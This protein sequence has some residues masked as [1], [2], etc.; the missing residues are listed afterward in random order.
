[1]G[2]PEAT[3]LSAAVAVE[4][5]VQVGPSVGVLYH[6]RVPESRALADELAR[7]LATRGAR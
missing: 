1:M 3:R 2:S 6:P 7:E 4:A 5:P